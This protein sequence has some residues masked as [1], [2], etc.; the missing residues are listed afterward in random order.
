MNALRTSQVCV[1]VH[2]CGVSAAMETGW[3]TGVGK[4]VYVYVPAIREPDLMLKMALYV[5]QDLE[6]LRRCIRED[7][8]YFGGHALG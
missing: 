2:P 1:M 5:T 8:Q 4:R 7:A 6:F 3:A